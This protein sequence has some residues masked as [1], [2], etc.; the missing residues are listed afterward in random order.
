MSEWGD[1]E[2]CDPN[3]PEIVNEVLESMRALGWKPEDLCNP[4]DARAYAEWLK[5]APL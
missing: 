1:P 4:E 3:D 5:T 2:P